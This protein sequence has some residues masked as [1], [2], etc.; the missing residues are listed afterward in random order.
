MDAACP[1]SVVLRV[2]WETSAADWRILAL[3]ATETM[4]PAL[5]S[6]LDKLTTRDSRHLSGGG[7]KRVASVV[8]SHDG[9]KVLAGCDDGS[10][11]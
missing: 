3:L 6:V 10:I 1:L 2:E 5:R 9:K 7:E 8:I 11:R 4:L